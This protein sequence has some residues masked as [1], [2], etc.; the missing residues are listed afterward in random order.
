MSKKKQPYEKLYPYLFKPLLLGDKTLKNRIITAPTHHPFAIGTDNFLNE[1]GITYYG[2][3]ARGGAAVVTIGEAKL[4]KLN[5]R[6][7]SMSVSGERGIRP[8]W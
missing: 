3:K 4:D 5:S 1:A 6:A 7:A 8:F 2:D